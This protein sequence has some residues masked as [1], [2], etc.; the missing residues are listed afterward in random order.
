MTDV[1]GER[2]G[3]QLEAVEATVVP[4]EL[5]N[6]RLQLEGRPPCRPKNLGTGQRPSLQE[7]MSF[8]PVSL[9][10]ASAMLNR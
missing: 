4:F 10:F 3:L 5:W 2:F 1:N 6:D 9:L 7:A 8:L